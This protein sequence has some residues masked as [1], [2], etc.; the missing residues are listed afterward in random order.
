MLDRDV[1][2]IASLSLRVWSG[3][4]PWSIPHGLH[5]DNRTDIWVK[6]L[7]KEVRLDCLNLIFAGP[8]LLQTL[9]VRDW[10]LCLL[11]KQHR[12]FVTAVAH[13]SR[14][15]RP[16]GNICICSWNQCVHDINMM[17]RQACDRTLVQQGGIWSCSL[18]AL[19]MSTLFTSVLLS[20]PGGG[21]QPQH[22][23]PWIRYWVRYI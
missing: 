2:M 7:R 12:Q 5:H 19:P 9:N 18:P 20:S 17:Y 3:K 16:T 11:D 10:H 21:V 14:T 13:S 6:Y 4:R 22:P 1:I 8:M 15:G 23:P